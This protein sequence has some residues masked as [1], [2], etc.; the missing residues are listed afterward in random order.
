[1]RINA[2]MRWAAL[3]IVGISLGSGVCRAEDAPTTTA[4]ATQPES[5]PSIAVLDLDKAAR[6]LG[7][8]AGLQKNLDQCRAQLQADVKQFA[9]MYDKQVQSVARSM[10]PKDAQPNEKF[11]LNATQSA[12]L[13]RDANT[14]RQQVAQLG[15][16]ADQLF[17]AYRQDCIRHYREALTP[18]VR[19]VARDRKASVVLAKNDSL[20]FYDAATDITDAVVEAARAQPPDV[21]PVVMPRLEAPAEVNFPAPPATQPGARP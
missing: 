6:D 19:Q 9:G 8:A 1:M 20:M 10:V 15:Q 13:S 12:E 7:F 4:P 17:T 2:R 16:K 21:V 5:R 3:S 11:Q 18:I 14:A